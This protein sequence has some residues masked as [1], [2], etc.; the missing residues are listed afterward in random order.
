MQMRLITPYP[1]APDLSVYEDR[2]SSFSS[3]ADTELNYSCRYYTV[4]QTMYNTVAASHSTKLL[5]CSLPV[6]NEM[7]LNWC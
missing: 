6:M 7:G 5:L 2:D 4:Y 3:N 1:D